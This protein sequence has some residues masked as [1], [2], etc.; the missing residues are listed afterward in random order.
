MR[1]MMTLLSVLAVAA[2]GGCVSRVGG[3][4]V[5]PS[6][7]PV[8]GGEWI[9]TL[10]EPRYAV[11]IWRFEAGDL[12]VE[13]VR[14][15]RGRRAR[16][17]L[18]GTSDAGTTHTIV[19]D[20]VPL[21]YVFT[22][23]DGWR[24]AVQA[25]Y[26]RTYE[27]ETYRPSAATRILTLGSVGTSQTIRWTIRSSRQQLLISSTDE[28]TL[29]YAERDSTLDANAALPYRLTRNSHALQVRLILPGREVDPSAPDSGPPLPLFTA[30]GWMITDGDRVLAVVQRHGSGVWGSNDVR[31]WL[32]STASPEERRARMAVLL[33]LLNAEGEAVFS[34]APGERT[35]TDR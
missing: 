18:S 13:D 32:P 10:I 9:E 35:L 3:P 11:H 19:Y 6:W 7:I 14:R 20:S 25:T 21:R 17:R 23:P 2:L 4:S 31:A 26:V 5:R 34:T 16:T 30:A 29:N 22:G 15:G 24:S 1:R 27:M 28:W 8:E 12:A 33:M